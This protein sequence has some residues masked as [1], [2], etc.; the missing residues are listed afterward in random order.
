MATLEQAR[1]ERGWTQ[2]ALAARAG[3]GESTVYRVEQ[4]RGRPRL[5][6]ALRLAAALGVRPE[7]IDELRAVVATVRLQPTAIRAR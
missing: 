7:E 2:S 1:R 6:V 3:I 4:R 5:S